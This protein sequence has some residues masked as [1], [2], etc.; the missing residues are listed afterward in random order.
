MITLKELLDKK[1]STEIETLRLSY[2]FS[3]PGNQNFSDI[4]DLNN[5]FEKFYKKYP[6]TN[7]IWKNKDQVII[8]FN[9]IVVREL[10]QVN[11]VYN[12][13]NKKYN[14]DYK[15]YFEEDPKNN[16]FVDFD[17]ECF[18]TNY[19]NWAWSK[20]NEDYFEDYINNFSPILEEKYKL[21]CI[22]IG[23]TIPGYINH[24]AGIEKECEFITS[25]LP[26][27]ELYEVFCEK[28][29]YYFG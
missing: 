26:C 28:F 22:K 10:E 18:N 27:N 29:S 9:K 25:P 20:V 3:F 11:E 21:T 6:K 24:Y 5:L 7:T 12:N 17:Y 1:D 15:A 16:I 19:D 14:L 4:I 23:D 8:E 2:N 13:F